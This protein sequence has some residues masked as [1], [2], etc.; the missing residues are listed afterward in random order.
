MGFYFIPLST[1]SYYIH[2]DELAQKENLFDVIPIGADRTIALILITLHVVS[3]FI[4]FGNPL[5]QE[6]EEIIG[7]RKG[8]NFISLSRRHWSVCDRVPFLHIHQ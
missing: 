6:I 5:F 8:D 3:G 4:I 7:V 2:G 1:I